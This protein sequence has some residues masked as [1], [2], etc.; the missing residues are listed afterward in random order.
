MRYHIKALVNYPE[1]EVE[2]PDGDV[3]GHYG[4]TQ[5]VSKLVASEPEATSFLITIV[6][7]KTKEQQ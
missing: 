4:V 5:W 2:T 7:L 3:I 1:T 6:P